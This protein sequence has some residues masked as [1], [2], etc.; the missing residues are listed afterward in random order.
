MMYSAIALISEIHSNN[1]DGL[2]INSP[3]GLVTEGYTLGNYLAGQN[4]DLP[5]YINYGDGCASACAN[6]VAMSDNLHINGILAFHPPFIMELQT[7]VTLQEYGVF[8][9][10]AQYKMVEYFLEHG[11]SLD[12]LA[13]KFAVGTPQRYMVITNA[14]DLYAFRKSN[15]LMIVQRAADRYQIWNQQRLDQY[16]GWNYWP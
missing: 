11:Y 12:F 3:G 15:P 9:S 2:E 4:P 13:I 10:K 8:V 7:N 1:I 14:D 5:I 6:A 16:T